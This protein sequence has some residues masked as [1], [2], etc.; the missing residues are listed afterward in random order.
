[1]KRISILSVLFVVFLATIGFA[2][3]EALMFTKVATLPEVTQSSAIVVHDGYLYIIG[4]YNA[5]TGV[6]DKVYYAQINSDGSIGTLN[7]TSAAIPEARLFY[8]GDGCCTYGDYIYIVG[9][10]GPGSG[11]WQTDTIYYAA[12]APNGDISSWNT[13]NTPY[14]ID[15][16]AAV[17]YN[18]YLYII[19]GER[20]M[21]DH[22]EFNW[23]TYAPLNPDGSPGTWTSNNTLPMNSFGSKADVSTD[24]Y[25]FLWG[26]RTGY[27][28][29]FTF[30][31]ACWS[32]KLNPD[33]SFGTWNSQIAMP[34][35]VT[36]A[37][38]RI[39]KGKN[40]IFSIAG[41]IDG[42]HDVTSIY[43]N[44]VGTG[45]VLNMSS[46]NSTYTYPE[47]SR[48]LGM[49]SYETGGESYLYC[50]GGQGT[51]DLYDSVYM[52]KFFISLGAAHWSMYY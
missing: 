39:M 52:G 49:A 27:S 16:H 41:R 24:G 44:E 34:E 48:Y 15:Y 51:S 12:P 6:W 11:D 20:W 30:N 26:G 4:G 31:A 14:G 21:T 19:G 28:T 3:V 13:A 23:F 42:V 18:G 22:D 10:T 5:T 32:A 8:N 38:G 9:G 43:W 29:G 47:S 33:G 7:E 37:A 45:G 50:A 25:L 17:A 1:M 2:A 35:G 36:A 40:R 46:W